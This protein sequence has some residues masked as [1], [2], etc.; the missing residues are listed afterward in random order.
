MN[1]FEFA[2]ESNKIEGIK[3]SPTDAEINEHDRFINQDVITIDDLKQFISIYQSNARL[4]DLIGLNV[5]VGSHV[6]PMGG[7]MIKDALSS[8][9]TNITIMTPYEA[10]VEYEKIHPFTDGNGRSGRALW[11]WHMK[12]TVGSYPLGFLHH[13]YY[14]SLDGSRK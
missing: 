8:L 4:R 12:Q 5:R 7:P 13:F 1:T 2:T 14:Q 3:R 10:H 11:A 6:P 9:L